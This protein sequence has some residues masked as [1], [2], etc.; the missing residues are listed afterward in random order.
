MAGP[1]IFGEAMVG[2]ARLEN[3]NSV[4]T[5]HL[6]KTSGSEVIQGSTSSVLA[7][8]HDPATALSIW[9]RGLVDASLT[10]AADIACER[11]IDFVSN[12]DLLAKGGREQFYKDVSDELHGS[13][14]PIADDLVELARLVYC[15]CGMAPQRVRLETVR[16]DG[17]CL[18]HYD[19]VIMRLVVA[20]RGPGTQW[21]ASEFSDVAS[22]QQKKFA[23]PINELQTGDVALFRGR[24]SA[25]GAMTLHRSPP[26]GDKALVR[27]V[28]VIDFKST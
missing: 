13:I 16:D 28:G 26:L 22:A 25:D 12:I 10:D 17:C 2:R 19:N 21:V 4:M 23:G 15:T 18:F 7:S 3:G 5:I 9:N 8:I 24:Q 6:M 27:L 1:I 20:Y 11:S 14:A